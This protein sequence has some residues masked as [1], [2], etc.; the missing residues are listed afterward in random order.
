ML[1]CD[2]NVLN[3]ECESKFYIDYTIVN[4]EDLNKHTH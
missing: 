1:N 3:V 2:S 4:N